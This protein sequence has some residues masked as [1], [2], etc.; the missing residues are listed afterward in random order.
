MID[1]VKAKL[2]LFFLICIFRTFWTPRSYILGLGSG[3]KTLLGPTNVDNQFWFWKYSPIF[4][5]LI[6][7]HFQPLLHFFGLFGAIFWPFLGYYWGQ[8]QVQKT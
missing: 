7:S 4:L 3:S 5:F 2:H 8:D 6:Q 1:C